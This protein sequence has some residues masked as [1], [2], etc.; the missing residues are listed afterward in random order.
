MRTAT[1]VLLGLSFPT[2]AASVE[3]GGHWCLVQRL[4]LDRGFEGPLRA[5]LLGGIALGSASLFAQPI[6]ARLVRPPWS[7]LVAWPASLWMGVALSVPDRP[8]RGRRAAPEPEA[9]AHA[10]AL[11]TGVVVAFATSFA[12]FFALRL[13]SLSRVEIAPATRHR[14]RSAAVAES[15]RRISGSS[16][17]RDANTASSVVRSRNRPIPG[18]LF[19]S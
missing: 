5:V 16:F 6:A 8:R 4:M 1:R 17:G 12:L 15:M 18:P 2:L 13:P 14:C 3:L 11:G 9:A 7:R 19:E 10:Q